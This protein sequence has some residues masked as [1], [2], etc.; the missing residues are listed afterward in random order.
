MSSLREM[1]PAS[2]PSCVTGTRCA[3]GDTGTGGVVISSPT[4]CTGEE[5]GLRHHGPTNERGWPGTAVD[6][7]IELVFHDG[8]TLAGVLR[9]SDEHA[10]VIETASDKPNS[11][12]YKREIRLLRR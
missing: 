7:P 11:L 2:S 6:E 12:I 9:G 10:I 5:Q 3:A 8:E 4:R 1:I